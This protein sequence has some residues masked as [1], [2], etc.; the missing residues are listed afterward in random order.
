MLVN[1]HT[2]L[3]MVLE[4]LDMETEGFL[5]AEKTHV[6]MRRNGMAFRSKEAFATGTSSR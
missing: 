1:I 2:M 6:N 3:G 4:R 5:N